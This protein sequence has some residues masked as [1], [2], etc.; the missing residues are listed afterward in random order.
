MSKEKL[1]VFRGNNLIRLILWLMFTSCFSGFTLGQSGTNQEVQVMWNKLFGGP[2]RE[3]GWSCLKTNDQGF[4]VAGLTRSFGAGEVDA[5]IIKTDYT[6][7][8]QWS[9]TFGGKKADLVVSV[10]STHDHGLVAAGF[11]T[12][13]CSGR[14]GVYL[15]RLDSE[16]TVKWEKAYCGEGNDRGSCVIA[17]RSNEYVVCGERTSTDT[18]GQDIL[19]LKTDDEGKVIWERTF[20]GKD[21]EVGR[22]VIQTEDE[23]YLIGGH[24]Q[25][26][27]SDN[28]DILLI[29]TDSKGNQIWRKTFGGP[30]KEF[31]HGTSGL[32]QSGDGGFIIGGVTSSFGAGKDDYYVIKASGQGELVWQKYFGGADD[33][34]PLSVIEVEDGDLVL[35]GYTKSF[36]VPNRTSQVLRIDSQGK[37]KWRTTLGGPGFNCAICIQAVSNNEYVICGETVNNSKGERDVYLTK[38]RN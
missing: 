10:K 35:A 31:I 2:Q 18:T 19:L 37:E 38:I 29:R 9:R 7:E 5:Y 12:S 8:E 27:G 34:H 16:G 17:N 20:G 25:P 22:S 26:E 32:I 15:I 24:T 36:G 6:G 30:G 14:S 33:D 21:L 1:E 28:S 13:F 11:T 4:V 3:I 23:G